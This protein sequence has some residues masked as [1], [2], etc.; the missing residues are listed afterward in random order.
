MDEPTAN[1]DYGNQARVL[2]EIARL[3]EAGIGVLVSTHHPE[4]AFRIADRVL[5]LAAG[6]LVAQ[7]PDARHAHV[8]GAVVALRPP[9][10]GGHRH[11]RRRD[12]AARLRARRRVA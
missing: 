10:R 6:R 2:E 1:L 5:L 9:D 12:L 3:K 8:G 4:H 7:G 11:A